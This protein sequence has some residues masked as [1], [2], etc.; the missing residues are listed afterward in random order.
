MY[1]EALMRGARGELALCADCDFDGFRE[2]MIGRGPL[3]TRLD[4]LATA[5]NNR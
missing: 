2:P 4:L 1:R 3:V 5:G